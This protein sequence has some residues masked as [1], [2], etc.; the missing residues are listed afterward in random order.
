MLDIHPPHESIH[1]WRDFF[2]HIATICVGLL[3][4]VGLEQIVEAVH[5][6]S[7]R[8]EMIAEFHDE[9]ERN[10]VILRKDIDVQIS[11]AEWDLAAIAVLKQAP[12]VNSIVRVTLPQHKREIGNFV[13]REANAVQKRIGWN[14]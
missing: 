10:V 9:A 12:V 5:H 8:R 13:G 2:I 11:E 14:F 1:S 6:A 3:L 4:A 7:E